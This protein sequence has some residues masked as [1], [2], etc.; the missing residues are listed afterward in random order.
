M[1]ESQFPVCH[2]AIKLASN[3]QTVDM[4]LWIDVC[5]RSVASNAAGFT[6]L[7]SIEPVSPVS[8]ISAAWE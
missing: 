2:F 1:V 3:R 7:S 8:G 5:G 4:P 6:N